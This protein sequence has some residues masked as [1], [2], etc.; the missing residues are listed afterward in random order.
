[1]PKSFD[2]AVVGAGSF[3]SWT[4]YQL[5]RRGQSVLLLDAYGPG[6]SRAS[7]GGESR[8]IRAGYGPCELYSRWA[9]QA[10]ELWQE[11]FARTGR[12]L[13][14]GTG[15]LWLGQAD[16]S[17]NSQ[18][19]AVFKKLGVPHQKFTRAELD[20]LYPQF[21]LDEGITW[22]LLETESGV[23]M[24]RRA[25]ATVVEEA[26]GEG[27]EYERAAVARPKVGENQ[28][29]EAVTTE[30]GSIVSAG[31]FVFACGPWLGKLFPDLLASLIVPT[32]Q[33]VFFFGTPPGDLRF[34]PPS[35]PT[36][37]ELA[38][39]AY[40]MPE[41]D[42]RG[43]KVAID[44]HGP[45]FDPDTD[46]RLV[47]P[48]GAQAVRKYLAHRLPSLA[49]AP[50][51]ET[52]VCQYENT[53]NGDFLIDRHPTLQNVWLVGGGSGHGFKH[54]PCVGEYVAAR[55]IEGGQ[56]EARFSLG[57]KE[58]ARNRTIF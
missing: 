50:L 49:D 48:E 8:I 9:L 7:S 17:Y 15:V 55:I 27:V 39:E 41:L 21:T 29:L 32:R 11:L 5:R 6:N 51:V 54:G 47:T 25:A 43:L 44:R 19:L 36:W 22:G 40:G 57:S 56:V 38:E 53:S 1:M 45:A 12:P 24:A 20:R 42:H 52:R 46:S 2:V 3:G 33:E 37:I 23:L 13:F 30:A 26:I 35:L 18:S 28:R 34:T 14:H 58:A 4:A 10:L 16:D 31:T